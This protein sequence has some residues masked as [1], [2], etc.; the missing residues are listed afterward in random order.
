MRKKD[1]EDTVLFDDSG[2][3]FFIRYD[4]ASSKEKL[5]DEVY[6][7][8]PNLDTNG[9]KKIKPGNLCYKD[10]FS[11]ELIEIKEI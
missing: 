4:G 10:K 8:Q 11:P 7:D 6:P 9:R 2:I 3:V 1:V 5:L